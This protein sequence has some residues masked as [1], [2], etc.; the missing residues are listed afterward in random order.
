MN[1]GGRAPCASA[2]HPDGINA[3]D[4][5]Q[6]PQGLLREPPPVDRRRAFGMR[7]TY[8]FASQSAI[9]DG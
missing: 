1:G 8:S 9:R 4:K 2:R 5:G 3:P 6:P 7:V